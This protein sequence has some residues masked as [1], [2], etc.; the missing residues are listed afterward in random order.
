MNEIYL[1]L[2]LARQILNILL[3]P[4]HVDVRLFALCPQ[5]GVFVPSDIVLDLKISVHVA[6]FFFFYRSENWSLVCFDYVCSV[7]RR[8][9]VLVVNASSLTSCTTIRRIAAEENV[10][11][12]IVVDD[13][14]I[15]AVALQ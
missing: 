14:L 4:L 12:A 2:Q 9:V 10:T 13:L 5:A 3:L 7:H 1:L 6:Y 11:A 15:D 8:L